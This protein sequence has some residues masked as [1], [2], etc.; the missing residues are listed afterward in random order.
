[1]MFLYPVRLL[2]SHVEL[3]ERTPPLTKRTQ[4]HVTEISTV[5][6]LFPLLVDAEFEIAAT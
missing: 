5:Q 3:R 1:M 6:P 2:L 4:A